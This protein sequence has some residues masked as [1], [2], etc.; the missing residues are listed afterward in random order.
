MA[1]C[2]P[3][4]IVVCGLLGCF[5]V[6]RALRAANSFPKAFGLYHPYHCRAIL[7][8]LLYRRRNGMELASINIKS[9]EYISSI[10]RLSTFSTHNHSP[11]VR[12]VPTNRVFCPFNFVS[13]SIDIHF[14]IYGARAI[15]RKIY[16]DFQPIAFWPMHTYSSFS[17]DF[18]FFRVFFLPHV[19]IFNDAV[20]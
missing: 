3:F 16:N 7:A 12:P 5:P 9:D 1:K 10:F 4:V 6:F 11:L 20:G 13:M 15:S 18:T 17:T 14:I 2:L 19:S 8:H